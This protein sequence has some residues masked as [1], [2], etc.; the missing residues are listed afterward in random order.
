MKKFVPFLVVLGAAA[1]AFGAY[2]VTQN[3]QTSKKSCDVAS[4]QLASTDGSYGIDNGKDGKKDCTSCPVG[5]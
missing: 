5:K 2:A 1:A 4:M 3:N